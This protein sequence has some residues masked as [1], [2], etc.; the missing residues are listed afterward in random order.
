MSLDD[1]DVVLID[2]LREVTSL[3]QSQVIQHALRLFH[4]VV[5]AQR[6][7]RT[8]RI[9]DKDVLFFIPLV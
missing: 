1:S 3:T 6:A 7:Q 9:A 4:Q 2:S 8:V 5:Q